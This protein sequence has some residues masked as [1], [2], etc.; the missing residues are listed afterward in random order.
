MPTKPVR[1]CKKGK[2]KVKISSVTMRQKKKEG[3]TLNKLSKERPRV[4]QKKL[5]RVECLTTQ[6]IL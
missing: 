3:L 1:K 5:I 2:G 4:T 6:V